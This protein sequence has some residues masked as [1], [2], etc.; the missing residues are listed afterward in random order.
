[1][2]RQMLCVLKR[3]SLESCDLGVASIAHHSVF[4]LRVKLGKEV[5]FYAA[6]VAKT[7]SCS[8]CH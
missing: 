8:V 6:A 1:M 4:Y 2:V 3:C 7:G 5:G